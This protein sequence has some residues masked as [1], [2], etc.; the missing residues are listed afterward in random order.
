MPLALNSFVCVLIK[1]LRLRAPFPYPL[2]IV[3]QK[4]ITFCC[5]GFVEEKVKILFHSAQKFMTFCSCDFLFSR[6]ELTAYLNS[7]E[8]IVFDSGFPIHFLGIQGAQLSGKIVRGS[9]GFS[10]TRLVLVGSCPNGCNLTKEML[11]FYG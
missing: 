1:A 11:Y 9:R 7:R 5:V 4:E 8:N 2:T 3:F 10:F 6:R